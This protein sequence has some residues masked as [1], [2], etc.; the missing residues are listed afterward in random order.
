MI[1]VRGIVR[2]GCLSLTLVAAAAHADAVRSPERTEGAVSVSYAEFD[3][4]KPAGASALYDRLQ[5]AAA[6]VCGLHNRT[7]GLTG[8]AS[9]SEKK[10]CY[11]E[12]LTRAIAELDSPLLREQHAG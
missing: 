11:Q 1:G 2:T 8:G 10:A 5:K 7:S 6:Q 9:T 4:S 12:A 3:L